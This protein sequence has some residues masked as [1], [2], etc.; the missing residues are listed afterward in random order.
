M[1]LYRIWEGYS[2]EGSGNRWE[3]TPRIKFRNMDEAIEEVKTW[4]DP[5]YRNRIDDTLG[6]EEMS[7]VEV[8]VF[9]SPEGNEIDPE[10]L[11]DDWE[12]KGYSWRN[13][14]FQIEKITER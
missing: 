9:F 2:D 14:Y 6:N 1:P 13:E 5:K 10:D 12:I 7:F 11:P 8:T 3:H 4:I